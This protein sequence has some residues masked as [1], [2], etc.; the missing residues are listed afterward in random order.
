MRQFICMKWGR[1]YGPEYVNRL[2]AMVCAHSSGPIRFVCLT[3]DRSGIRAEV[4]CHDCPEIPLP[5]PFNLRGWRKLTTYAASERLYGLSGQWL[6]LDLDVVV[7]GSLDDFFTY[8]PEKSFIVMRNW[9]QPGRN[10]GNTSV[11]RF[12]VGADEYLLS[13]LIAEQDAILATFRNSQTYISRTVRELVFWPDE[14]C[15]LFKTHCVPPWPLR[16][17]KAPTVPAG[18]RVVAFP[19]VPNPHEAVIGKWPAKAWKKSYKFIRPAPWIQQAWD[20][21]ETFVEKPGL[22]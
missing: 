19:G 16:F 13:R 18:A 14:W 10:I 4:E 21:A 12:T 20:S 17:W 2:Y 11:Y 15:V 1:L 7:L 9:T 6:F 22:V 8:Q 5:S 3:D